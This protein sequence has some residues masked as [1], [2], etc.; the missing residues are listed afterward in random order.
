VRDRVTSYDSVADYLQVKCNF[1][2]ESPLWGIRGN[3]WCSS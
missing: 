2:W 1:R 3:I